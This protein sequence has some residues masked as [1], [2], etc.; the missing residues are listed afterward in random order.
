VRLVGLA[1]RA[2]SAERA[3]TQW[4]DVLGG[5]VVTSDGRAIVVRWPGSPMRIAV[6]I[7]PA[8][9][10]GPVAVEVAADRPLDLSAQ[11]FFRQIEHL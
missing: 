8:A 7:D 6:T 3:L 5:E 9:E 1:L 4:R 2:R 11:A 10:E